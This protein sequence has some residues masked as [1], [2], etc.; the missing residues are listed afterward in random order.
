LAKKAMMEKEQHRRELV[1]VDVQKDIIVISDFVDYISDK[2]LI[3]AYF[4]ELPKQAGKY[5][6]HLSK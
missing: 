2:W 5:L 3:K 6:V 1:F 4:Q